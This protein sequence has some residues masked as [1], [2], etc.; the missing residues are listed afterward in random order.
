MDNLSL[1]SAF[2]AG[3]LSFLSPCIFPLLPAY[4]SHLTGSSVENGKLVVHRGKMFM[5]S[6][7]FI[8]GFSLVFIV[9]GA[10]ASFVG[11]LFAKER[12]LIQKLSGLLIIIFGLQMAGI[13]NLRLLM[14]EKTW[15]IKTDRGRGVIRSLLTG[16][17]FGAGWS[18][19][20]GFALSAILFLAGS[21][22]TLWNGVGL[23]SIYSLGM[24]VPFLLISWL[25]TYSLQLLKKI[26]KWVPL[27]SK[28]NGWLLIGLGLLLFTGQLQ[29]ISAWL[30][31]FTFW[32]INF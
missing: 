10:S 32:D 23:L 17:A 13:L 29:R 24:G 30:A 19:C 21:S 25:L 16:V 8:A 22:E 28:L 18:P 1:F 11:H 9:M 3:V 14:S 27:L 2:A 26:N 6:F 4:I 31:Q 7:F 12:E 5:L 15:E 20:V